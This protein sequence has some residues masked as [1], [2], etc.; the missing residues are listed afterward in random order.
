MMNELVCVILAGGQG[1]RMA[2]AD[3]HKVCFP[4][5]GKPA[6]V[7]AIDTYKAAGLRR[8]LVVVGQKAAQV[9]ATVS[10]VHPDVSFVCQLEP[11]G[12]GHAAAVAADALAAQA[13]RG[14]AMI[15]M[16]D[17]VTRPEVVRKLLDRFEQRQPDV[18]LATLSKADHPTSGRVL[19]DSHGRALAIVEVPDIARARRNH[20]AMTVGTRKLTAAQLEKRCQTVNASMYVFWFT[21]LQESLGRLRPGN[22]QGELYL[23]DTVEHISR[24]GRAETMLVPN[25]NDLMAFN[26]PAELLA[27]EEVVRTREKPSRVSVISRKRLSS[28][29]LKRAGDWLGAVQS[30]STTWRG[31]LRRTYGPD[32]GFL[33]RRRK[34][35][36][37]LIRAF[38]RRFGP[39]RRMILLRAPGRVNLMGRHVDHRGGFVNV[40]G[41]GREV[42]LAAAP[43]DDDVVSLR[44][45]QPRR[46]PARQFRICDLLSGA[47]WTD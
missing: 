10:R 41:I 42:L 5:V 8:F 28:R 22:V 27:V 44:N 25:P 36:G 32:E 9:I 4:I 2:S 19:T 6:I 24:A 29:M 34:A 43:R 7:R 20:T 11:R 38:I 26:T 17:R 13:Y 16:G 40:M 12:T 18:L 15:V 31:R 21:A 46:F 23:T 45:V 33:A 47:S 14:A 1:K 30:D 37:Q 39:E 35:M 3:L